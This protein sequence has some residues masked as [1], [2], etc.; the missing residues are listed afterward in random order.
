ME[1]CSEMRVDGAVWKV[2]PAKKLDLDRLN[3]EAD[4]NLTF[5][6]NFLNEED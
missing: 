5:S 1:K 3:E 2:Q 4:R 6:K